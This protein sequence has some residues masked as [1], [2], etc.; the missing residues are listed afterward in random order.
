M[1]T[2]F[3]NWLMGFIDAEG[4]FTICRH[5]NG[6]FYCG[7][8][9]KLR[10]DDFDV[11]NYIQKKTGIGKIEND[12]RNNKND[13]LRWGIRNKSDA[14]KLCDIIS[15]FGLR[16]KKQYD[17]EI[18]KN[19]VDYWHSAFPNNVIYEERHK[20]MLV[21]KEEIQNVK[22]FTSQ[23]PGIQL[24]N[25]NNFYDWFAGFTDGEGYIGMQITNWGNFAWRFE[26]SQ[27]TDDGGLIAQIN[28][29]LNLGKIMQRTSYANPYSTL[30]VQ[31]IQDCIKI[32]NILENRMHSKKMRDLII[33][34]KSLDE[35]IKTN[36]SN[37]IL[38]E[39]KKQLHE[40]KTYF[41]N[42]MQ[43]EQ[44]SISR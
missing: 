30:R 44:N 23:R 36:P 32:C 19:A 43:H 4:C 10:A 40:V 14:K 18:W 15:M 2:Q 8:G 3:G 6:N 7:F 13:Q 25:D 21:F 26:V 38:G 9:L 16:S 28:E 31:K 42:T 39:F 27:R 11:L 24:I 41:S 37:L 34:K 33:W 22:K 5:K 12:K 29:F 35:K 20:T 1:D 17:F